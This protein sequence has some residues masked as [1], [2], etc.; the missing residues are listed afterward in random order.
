MKIILR[1]IVFVALA[2][3]LTQCSATH[4]SPFCTIPTNTTND[5]TI[6]NHTLPSSAY[7]LT[8]A[9]RYSW[10]TKRSLTD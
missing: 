8:W 4:T 10:L 1:K 3:F 7:G 5:T 9:E 6:T 2:F